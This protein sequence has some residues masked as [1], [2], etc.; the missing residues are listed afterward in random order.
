MENKHFAWLRKQVGPK[1]A[2]GCSISTHV[3]GQSQETSRNSQ[4]V[5]KSG[6]DGRAVEKIILGEIP[7][8][9]ACQATLLYEVRFAQN[10]LLVV[11]TH[12][13]LTRLQ[14]GTTASSIVALHS[15]IPDEL[16][17]LIV[18]SQASLL[19][20]LLR[21]PVASRLRAWALANRRTLQRIAS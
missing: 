6:S 1:G 11:K 18:A 12:P 4:S 16:E 14:V 15:T 2:R 20:V 3:V 21:R 17:D 8:Q 7:Q 5:T 13:K 19:A 9:T 10:G